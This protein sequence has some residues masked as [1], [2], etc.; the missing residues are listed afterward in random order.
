M[1]VHE[2]LRGH[3]SLSLLGCYTAGSGIPRTAFDFLKKKKKTRVFSKEAAPAGASV[4]Q[5]LT[6]KWL[7]CVH[8]HQQ[9][10]R[11]LIA[12]HPSGTCY[13]LFKEI[14]SLLLLLLF[15]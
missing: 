5:H 10:M 7:H 4:V 9:R 15:F 11:V 1:V 6:A 14:S 12:P 2:F 3:G 13:D 8:A